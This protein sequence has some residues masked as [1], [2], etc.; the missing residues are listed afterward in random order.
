ME[1]KVE[2]IVEA[3]RGSLAE[4]ERLRRTNEGLRAAADAAAEPVAIIGTACR[5]PGGVASPEDLWSLVAGGRDAIGPFPA[6]R[7][8]DLSALYDPEPGRPG[9]SYVRDGGFLYEAGD[10]D[11]GA[12]GISP[13]EALTMDPQQRLML[14]VVWEAM[15]RAGVDPVALRGSRTG[16]FAGAMYHDY[17]V[18]SSDGS[19]VSGRVAY[20]LGLEGPAVTVDTACSSSLVA[21][22]WAIQALRAGECGLALAGGVSVMATPETFIEFSEQRGLSP[23]GRCR[24]FAASADGTGW[25]EGAGVLLLEKLSD[26]RRNGHRVLAVVRG[27][28]VNQD[29]A[30]N[31]L[32]APNG[33]SQ[34]RVIGQALASAGLT[35]ADVDAVEGHGTGTTLGD[36][37]EV[38]ALLATYGKDREEPLW[39]GSVKSN[40]GHTQAAAGVAGI[41]KMVEAIRHGS[42]PPTLHVDEP[43]SAVDWDAGNVRLLTEARA[44]PA[45]DRPRRAAVSSFGVSGTNAHVI[46]EQ[47]AE[48]TG[49]PVAPRVVSDAPVLLPLGARTEAAVRA[50]ARRVADRLGADPDLDPV[51]VAY[52]LATGRAALDHRAAVVGRDRA[53]LLHGLTALADG[54][55][56]DAPARA[57]GLTAFLF[58]GQGSQRLG[59]GRALHAAFPAFAR[60]FDEVCARFDEVSGPGG[61]SVRDAMWAG[62]DALNRTE[63]TQPAIFALEVALFRLLDSWGVRPD[64]V[65]GHSI[66]ELAAAHVAGVFSLDDAARLVAARGRLMGALPPGGAMVAV[67]AREDEV[68]PLLGYGVDLAAVNGPTSVV[69]SGEDDAVEAVVARFADRRTNRLTVSHAF[70]SPLMDPMLADFRRVAA[71]VSYAA[72]SVPV[73]ADGDVTDP[74]HWVRHVRGTVRFADAVARLEREG[75][76]RYVEVGPDGVLTAMARQCLT[77]TADTAVLVPVLRRREDEPVAALTALGRL[78]TAGLPVDWDGVFDGRGAR[79][80]DLP[81]YPF[82]RA[83]YWLDKRG[84]SGDVSAAGLDRPDHPLLGAMVP[85][86]GSDGVVFTGRLSAGAHAWLADHVVLGSVLLPGTAYVELA[87]RAADEVG[88]SGVEELTLHAPLVLPEHGGVQVQAAVGG[89]DASGRRAVTI[90]SR[91][92]D[93]PLDR[94]WVLHA[95]GVLTPEPASAGAALEAWPPR[96]A[97]PLPV[98]GLYDR[99]SYGPSFHGLRAAWQRGEE[100]FTEIALPEGVEAAG[101]GLHPALL[102]AALHALDLLHEDASVLPFTWSDVV[103][104]ASGATAARVR[105]RMRGEDTV[106]LEL[107]DA[108]GRPVASVGALTLRPVTADA[109][110]RDLD[111]LFRVEWVPA[112]ADSSDSD[113]E[114]LVHRCAPSGEG[115]AAVREVVEAALAAVRDALERETRLIVVTD[116]ATDGS[117]LGHAAVWG[118]VRAAE[119]EHPGRFVLADTDASVTVADVLR[120]GAPELRIRGGAAEVPRLVRAVAGSDGAPVWDA[121]R[122]VLITGGTGALGAAVARHLVT[123]HGVWRLLLA[124][125]RGT[126]APGAVELVE[127][128]TRLGADVEVVACDIADRDAL[129]QLLDGRSLGG[130]VHAAGVLDDGVVTALT[131]SRLATVFRPKV[132]A[133][134]HLHD[135]TR[136]HDLTAFVTF[137]SVAGVLNAPGQ[138]N[139]AAANAFLDALALHRHASGLPALSPAW[140]PWAGDGMADGLAQTGMRALSRD[141]GLALL[142]AAARAGDPA[143]VP[144]RLDPASFDAPPPMLRGLIKGRSRRAVDA[145][146]ASATGALRRRLA[147]LTDEERAGE[148]LDLVRAQAAT[149]LRHAGPESVGPDRAFRDLGFDSLTAIELRNLLGAA[150]GLRLPA[151][152]VFDYPTAHDLAGYLLDELSGTDVVPAV[153]PAVPVADAHAADPIVI[154]G[155]ACRFPGG[156]RSPEELWRLVADGVD[157]VS[158]FPSDRGW[159]IAGIYDPE[160]GKPGKSY[161]RTGGFLHDAAEFDAHFFGISPREARDMDPQQR[162]LLEVSWEAL[163][164]AGVD[165]HA[166]KGSPTGVFAGVMYHDYGGGNAAGSIVS[167]RV[168]YTLGLEGPAVTVDTACSSS[169]VALHWAMQALRTGECSLALVGGVT[170]MATPDTFI[171]FSEQRG[172]SPDGRCKSFSSST[173]GTGWG[174]GAGMLVVERLSDARRNGHPVLAVVRGSA[175]NQDGASNGLTAPNGPSQ[176]RVIRHA[177]AN[178]GLSA[179]DVDAVEAHGTGTTLGDPIEAQALL[180][181]YGRDRDRAEPLWLG[182][183]KSN[184]GHTQ[185]AAGVAGVIK[186]VEAMRHGVLP[187]TLHVDEP[188][189]QVDW[190]AGDVRLLTEPRD[191]PEREAPRRAAVSSFGISGTNAHVILEQPPRASEPVA[192]ARRELPV[193]PL[194]ASAKTREALDVQLARLS[195]LTGDPLDVAYSAATGR[196]ALEHRAVRVGPETV[197]GSVEEGRLAFLFTGQGSQRVGMGR[198]LYET[199]PVFASAFDEVCGALGLPLKDVIWSDETRLNQTEFT[200]PAIFA[201]EVALFRLVESWGVRPDFLVGHSIGELAAAHVAGVL[202][203]E[204]AARLIVARGRLMQALLAGGAMVAIQATEDEVAS[205]L[206]D[207]VGI[208][209]V[210]SSSSLVI[211]G[212]EAAVAAIAG[213]FAD[214]KQTRLTVSHAFH[215]PLMDPMLDE[216]RAVAE[217]VTYHEPK[218]RLVKDVASAEYWVR[219]V[220]EA[221]RFADDVQRLADEGVTCFL[222]IGPDGVLAAMAQQTVEGTMAATMRR[223]RDETASL[224]VGI[225][226]LFAAG[227]AVDWNAVFE[228][229]GAQRVELPTYP[230]QRRRFWTEPKGAA[231]VSGAGQQS[232]DHP[233]LKAVVALPDSDGLVLT[234]RL[235]L[236][237]HPWLADH[238]VLGTVLLPGTGLVE[239]ALRAA[240]QVGATALDELTL[241]APLVLPDRGGVAVQ[242]V[243]DTADWTFTVYS[244]DESTPDEPWTR[245]ATGRFAAHADAPAFDLAA[246]PPPGASPID[247][248]GAYESLIERG[249]GYGPVFQ[250]LRAAWRRG[251]ETFA[252]VVLPEGTDAGGFGVHPALLD[253]AMHAGLLDAEP[254][255]ALDAEPDDGETHLPFAWSDVVLH[256][257]GVSRARVRIAPGSGEGTGLWLA[258]ETGQPVL[259]VGGLVSRPV[260]SAQL[261]DADAQLFRAEW[262]PTTADLASLDGT[263][264]L[265]VPS[266]EGNVPDA[267]RAVTGEVLAAVQNVPDDERLIVVTNGALDGTNLAHAAVWG[268]VRA[269]EAESPGRFVLVDADAGLPAEL[270]SG[271]PEIAVRDGEIRVPRLARAEVGDAAP[272]WGTTVLVT[273]GLSGLGALTARHLAGE[274]GVRRLVLTSR[275]GADAPGAD[276]LRA[277]L[278]AL[279][280]D[281]V[282]EACDAAD[283]DALA[284][285]LDRYEI[286][287]VVHAAGVLD[288]GVLASLTADRLDTVF[289]PKVDAAWNLHELTAGRGLRAFVLFSS[290]AGTVGSAGQANYAAANAWLDALAEH[291]RALGLPVRSLAWGAWSDAG[292]MADRLDETEI[293]RLTRAGTPPLTVPEGL[294]AFDASV[295]T[296]GPVLLPLRLDLAALR[297]QAVA[298]GV[299]PAMLRGLV[300]VPARRD[301]GG[302]G[303]ALLDRLADLDPAGRDRAL[304]DLVRAQVASVLGHDSADAVEPDRAFK[305]LGFDS[306]TAV[307]LRN[308]LNA[309]TG[310]K[311]P[312]TLVFDFPTARAVADHLRDTLAGSVARTRVTASARPDDDEPIAIVATACRYPGGVTSP[313]DLWRL[314]ASGSDGIAGFPTGRGWE[315]EP[316]ASLTDQGGFLYDA[317]GFDAAF[318]GISPR[319]A[320]DMD[321]QQRLLL[322]ASWEALERAGIDPHTL[323]GSQTGVFAGV[324]YHDYGGGS[325]GSIV[326]GRVAYTLGLE[327]PAVS[328]DTACSS[329]LVALHWAIQALRSG[330]CTLALAGGVTVMA[331]PE[332]FI[333]FTRQRGLAADGRCKSFAAS[334]D[335]TGWGEGVGM[336]VVERLT[337]ARRLGHPVLAVVRGSAINQDG[338]SNGLTAPNGPSQQRVILQALANAGLRTS[339]VDAVEAHGTGTTLGDPIEAQA[340]L[341]TYGNDRD[342]GEPLWLGSIKSNIGHTQAAAGVA[343]I[344]KVIEAMRHDVL[345]KTLHVDEPSPQVDWDA[346]HVEL[347]TEAR[348][349]PRADRPRR[350]GVS[351]FGISGTN[352]HVIIEEAPEPEPVPAPERHELPAVPLVTS[353]ASAEALDRQ[354]ER[355]AE[356]ARD[357]DALDVAYSAATGRAVL[358]HRAVMV[359]GET[360]TGVARPGRLA[361]LFTGQGSQRVGMGRELYEVFPVFASAFDE[362]CGAL[363]LPLKDVIWGDEAR[364]NQ[365]EFT[366]PAIFALEVALFRL[367]ESWGVR[368]DFLVGHSIGELAAAHVAGVL[369]LEDAARLITARGRLMQALPAGG[370]MVA[371]QA[372][373]DEVTPLLTGKVGIAAVNSP[374]SL[375]ISGAENAVAE[376][377]ERF[378]DRK[379]TRLTVSHAFHSPLMDPMLDDFR[380]VAESVTYNEPKIRLAKDVGTPEYWVRHVREAVRFADDVR[381]VAD[382]GVTHFL[383]IGPDGVLTAMAQQTVEGTLAATLRRDRLETAS[384]FTGI[385]R[386][387]TAGVPVDWDAVFAGRGARRVLLP[388]YPFE[389]RRYWTTGPESL[390]SAGLDAVEHPLLGAMV[391]LPDTGGAVFTGRLS[392]D[393]QPWLADHDVLGTVLLPGTGLV[394]LALRAARQVGCDAVDELTLEAPLVVP[395]AGGAVAVRV[396]VGGPDESGARTIEIYSSADDDA[397]VRNATGSLAEQGGPAVASDLTAWPPQGATPLPVDGAYD[398]LLARGYDYGPV[399]RGLRAA[400]RRGG[401]VFAEV[402]LPEGAEPERYGVHPALLDAAMHGGLIEEDGEAP[403]LPFSWNGVTLHRPGAG[404]LRVRMAR[405][406]GEGVELSVAD[407][408]GAPVLSVGTLVS[409]PVSPAQLQPEDA[410]HRESLFSVTWTAASGEPHREPELYVVPQA[411]GGTPEAVR[412]LTARVLAK[413]QDWLAED[414]DGRLAVVTRRAVS[415]GGEDVDLAHAPIWGLVRAAEAENPGRFALVDLDT[416]G[417]EP[418]VLAGEPEIAVREGEPYLPRLTRVPAS[419]VVAERTPWHPDATV[420]ITGGTSGLGAIVARHLVTVHG[421]RRLVLTSRRGPDAPGAADLRAELTEHGADVAVEA[422]DVADRSA[423]AAV[424][425]RHPVDTVVHAA[426]VVDNALVGGLTPGSVDRVLRPKVDGAWNLHELT[427]DRELRAFVLFSSVGGLVLAAGQGNYAAANV[428][429][430]GLAAHRHGLGLPVTSLAFG[431]WAADTGLGELGDADLERMRRLGLP[432]LA[433]DEGLLL[434]DD[435]LRTDEPS[436]APFRLDAAALRARAS[437][438]DGLPALLRGLIRMPRRRATATAASGDGGAE[439][440]RKL[441]ETADPAERDR[442]LRD[443]VRTHVASVL[444]HDSPDAIRPDRPFQELGFDSL[445]AVELRNA[446]RAATG[447]KLP[448]TLVFDHP[449]PAAIAAELHEQLGETASGPSVLETELARLEAAL[450]SA[451]PA[452]GDYDRVAERLR[453]LTTAWTETHR[454]AAADEADLESASAAELFDILDEELDTRSAR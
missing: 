245:N 139:Y 379:Q 16:V 218:V 96:D 297:A 129:A 179:S 64:L 308:A 333:E 272:E 328:V 351:S 149:V 26:A 104:H 132:D 12:F 197:T 254:D 108:A 326:S 67:E 147:G 359:D 209:A 205:L 80:V 23:D 18:T 11:P 70:H 253:A 211:S 410:E 113:D 235:G 377:A 30:S 111:A 454:P 325:N 315:V 385:G 332:T 281:V 204:D 207:Q 192:D 266:H 316:G 84:G 399:F 279:G 59:M 46:I 345:P 278:T 395:E 282:I 231:D 28:A 34:R 208:A 432:A 441:T 89:A 237:S 195:D 73:I 71:S 143:P 362:V 122:T 403:H 327:G 162:I 350:A 169:L 156:A 58:T 83:R 357:G 264:V 393:A 411:E 44:W 334:A 35:P 5:L 188:T 442:I 262:T 367:V 114:V 107:A 25:G 356:A 284:A 435:A 286:D 364:L 177:L 301:G 258:D 290:L 344:I 287:S 292:G 40:I 394:E 387:F 371:I 347:L 97:T 416:A 215:S 352:A 322:E 400:W 126:A 189:P 9:K 31:G 220:R 430:D 273:G 304:L 130:V 6:D 99:L 406:D 296:E 433:R 88:Y 418:V 313:E 118:L 161:V 438:E 276:E 378:A 291:R 309:D 349:W 125:R 283:R 145:A 338:A 228:G 77:T 323:K 413:L 183:I 120:Y 57:T 412:A 62:E 423:L 226:R 300:R 24:S 106:S 141:D 198:E 19:L 232:V 261:R 321:P 112:A 407:E 171:D 227:V 32:T 212:G 239:V 319:E 366:Q 60:A 223:D 201:L 317:A 3:L 103:L 445:T 306:L 170:V 370:A 51:D 22:H 42:L 271:E 20:T 358:E 187:R 337:D 375:V 244:R 303:S 128:L 191:W 417:A 85:L 41:I 453:A 293:R 243:L 449:T 203:L 87:V 10:F 119:G 93:A 136:D 386:L 153:A 383:E 150:T 78:H 154:V 329:S 354:I 436:L 363:D 405:V 101:F 426:G 181:T 56:L 346:G 324:M 21:L 166:L 53:A 172:L 4:N 182:S 79:R 249:Y 164:R 391:Q 257:P 13:R 37:I 312:A 341:A 240:E 440:R 373:E 348:E 117:D 98:D 242:V 102:D 422:C 17:G 2:E 47:A 134:W 217:S 159:D 277:D 105:L 233:L 353:A 165:P 392:L 259:Q 91:A 152:L 27:S 206:D 318:F 447:L 115:P 234:G 216:F 260:S 381:H 269:A 184:F 294:A 263:T 1:P 133:A 82:Q 174:E 65:A 14:E 280:A 138:G 38:Q 285:L 15:E 54:A 157:A 127:D 74:E 200:Q 402:A 355:F 109:L 340:L 295:R 360:V 365:T 86:P 49:E 425:A 45:V 76:T 194:V 311:L 434:L 409:R 398:R 61:A 270:P 175:I 251:D 419:A 361:F 185:A 421:V 247:V 397:W 146:S 92:D 213:R 384:L 224:F 144:V 331:T 229:R 299:V 448:A 116:G 222:E 429:L 274:H 275:R 389:H 424:L 248:D 314:V 39:L 72:P 446:L 298:S 374:S 219:H 368:P 210:N 158:G 135:L 142:D 267:A 33:P 196:A 238:D 428:F 110:N 137:S 443:L 100:L 236:D 75:A 230:F 320:R 199:F 55:P 250:G 43:S 95:E 265:H 408:T 124:G 176:Q 202:S 256:R 214:R 252:E 444:G 160:P 151:T 302:G 190:D 48:E 50:Q 178:A 369:S 415:V 225:G 90:Y 343:G 382:Q 246:W 380:A 52:S 68:R 404:A 81:T 401:E 140:G 8:W 123:E 452:A 427:A 268:L 69:L 29:G 94:E 339:D 163:E 342:R 388:T 376:I 241:Q 305:D 414:G 66:G 307:E 121:S 7:G 289:R 439:L 288:D 221:V 420:L 335:G 396:V 131:P 193:V 155:M 310:L 63:T 186:M 180:A 431:L 451:H 168:A 173:D 450:T 36:P 167:G 148:L 390:G 437:A 255:D 336:L 330:E 372:T